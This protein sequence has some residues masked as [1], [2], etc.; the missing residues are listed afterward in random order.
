MILWERARSSNIEKVGYDTETKELQV[1][2]HSGAVYRYAGVPQ[3]IYED[4]KEVGYSGR[5]LNSTIKG[6]Y[7]YE[8]IG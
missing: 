1:Q 2:F 4:F 7:D 3:D 5:F 6:A 8:R